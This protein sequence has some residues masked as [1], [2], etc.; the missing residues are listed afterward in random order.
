MYFINDQGK[1][2]APSL[3]SHYPVTVAL[4]ELELAAKGFWDSKSDPVLVGTVQQDLPEHSSV[5]DHSQY[6]E[7][8]SEG[9]KKRK[10][11]ILDGNVFH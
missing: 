10:R 11:N 7:H 4:C 2:D 5:C 6:F 9:R 3:Y 1:A 8:K